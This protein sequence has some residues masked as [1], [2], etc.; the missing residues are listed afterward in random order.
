MKKISIAQLVYYYENV[1]SRQNDA[2]K[3]RLLIF[4]KFDFTIL[5]VFKICYNVCMF[6]L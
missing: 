1:W 4:N 5:N 6:I 2:T 3:L